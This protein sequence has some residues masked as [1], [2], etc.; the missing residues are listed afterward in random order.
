MY[1]VHECFGARFQKIE[2]T[3]KDFTSEF[4]TSLNN[5]NKE[6]MLDFYCFCVTWEI[7]LVTTLGEI[8]IQ[9]VRATKF[10]QFEN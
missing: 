3:L 2:H 9:K 7:K 8:L 1:T 5:T 10:F 4:K 6:L